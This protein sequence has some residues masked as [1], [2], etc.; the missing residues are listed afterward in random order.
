MTLTQASPDVILYVYLD[1][2]LQFFFQ[3][4]LTCLSAEDAGQAHEPGAKMS[5]EHQDSFARAKNLARMAVVCSH[6]RASLASC[7]RP[8]RVNL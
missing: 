1:V 6:W 4:T 5:K 7:L 8:A 2:A 3:L